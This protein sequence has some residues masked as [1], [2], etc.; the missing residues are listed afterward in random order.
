[1]L[2]TGKGDNGTSKLFDSASGER[3]S[4]SD[5]IY[6][7]LGTV[8]ELNSFLGLV[9]VR[10][11]QEKILLDS[12]PISE[13][14]EKLQQDLFIIQAE[15]A[16]A[17]MTI[18]SDKISWLEDITN[19][20]E[21]KMPPIKT[22]FISGGTELAALSDTARTIARRAERRLVAINQSGRKLTPETLAYINRLSSV[23]YALARFSNHVKNIQE[24]NPNYA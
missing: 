4:K 13:S 24:K 17:G 15:I 14:L 5:A 6:E 12:H 2:Y 16:G 20:I 3:L 7:A 11:D 18:S 9:K 8:D 22:F 19:N 21:S 23:L 1:M 10:F